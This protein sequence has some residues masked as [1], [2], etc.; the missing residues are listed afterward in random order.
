MS[1]FLDKRVE[2]QTEHVQR[3]VAQ[4]PQAKWA[5]NGLVAC[6]QDAER[7]RIIELLKSIECVGC[8]LGSGCSFLDSKDYLILV[9]KESEHD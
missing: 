1:A 7:E 3:I 9:I 6:V 5:V 2:Q 4:F 8:D